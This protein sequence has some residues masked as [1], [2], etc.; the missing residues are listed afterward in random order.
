MSEVTE[1]TKDAPKV[2]SAKAVPT[3]SLHVRF[4]K[5]KGIDVTRAAK[6]NRSYMRSNFAQLTKVWPEL[7][8]SQKINRDG[9]R[10]PATCPAKVANAIVTR[11]IPAQRAK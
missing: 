10:W 5:V 11:S 1:V 7:R 9:N 3:S 4:A 6:L 8:K 2:T